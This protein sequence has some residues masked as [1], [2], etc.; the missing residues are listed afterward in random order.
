MTGSPRAPRESAPAG[1]GITGVNTV[2]FALCRGMLKRSMLSLG[3]S[4]DAKK[5]GVD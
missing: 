1:F 3:W 4:E 2:A 5:T